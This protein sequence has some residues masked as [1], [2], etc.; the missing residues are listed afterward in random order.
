MTEA[1]AVYAFLAAF[2]VAALLTPLT[3]R[4]ARRV[5][6]V[7]Q[8]K[9]ARARRGLDAAARRPGDARRRPAELGPV[10]RLRRRHLGAAEGHPGRRRG[11]RLRRRPRRPLRP[12]AGGQAR[13]PDRRGRHP[14]RRGRRGHEHHAALRRRGQLRRRGRAAHGRRP[15]RGDERRQPLRRRRRA[16]RRG[17][18]DQRDHLLDHRLRPRPQPRGG[19]RR[20]HRRRGA[21]LPRSTTST[22]RRSTWAT[23][24]RT[25]SGCCSAA[26]PS[27]ARSRRRPSWPCSSRSSSSPCPSWTRRSSCSSA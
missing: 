19:L 25:C 2:V 23:A 20:H 6:A 26:S 1:D 22:R 14:G 5:G 3:A 16:R 15:R 4:L 9:R 8:P 24:G 12:A 21:G 13:R 17:L 11:H 18:R 27:R 7:D 10:P